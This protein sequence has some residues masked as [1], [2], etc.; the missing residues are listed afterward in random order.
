MLNDNGLTFEQ[1]M[2]EVDTHIAGMVGLTSEDLEDYCYYDA[3]EAGVG[4][5]ECAVEV[6]ER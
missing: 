5:Y 3:W 2:D 6:I 4:P 1:F